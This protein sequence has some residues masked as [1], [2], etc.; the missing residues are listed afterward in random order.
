[1]L[2]ED[3][4]LIS[5]SRFGYLRSTFQPGATFD[6][7][8]HAY[9]FLLSH[10]EIH[11]VAVVAIS[12]GC[13]SALLF[14]AMHPERV[15]SLALISCGVASS[16]AEDQAEANQKGD[17]LTRIFRYDFPYWA[18]TKVFRAQFIELMG[19]NSAVI[20]RLSGPQQELVDQLISYMNP[21]SMRADGVVFDNQAALPGHRIAAIQA[22]T[23]MVHAVDDTLQLFRNAEFAVSTIPGAR[24]LR[25]ETGGHLVVSTQQPA[26]RA[27]VRKHIRTHAPPA[28]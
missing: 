23:L 5:P 17:L 24:L 6:E 4:R 26:I 21:V 25:F 20:A 15:H 18:I 2:D 7:Q 8:A 27:A 28:P 1:M 9:A 11:Q 10:L 13:P 3:L 19:A 16:D 14:A 22:P 12:H